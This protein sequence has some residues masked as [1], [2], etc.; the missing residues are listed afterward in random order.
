MNVKEKLEKKLSCERSMIRHKVLT[1]FMVI[2]LFPSTCY[3]A[4]N[5]EIWKRWTK[6]APQSEQKIDHQSWNTFLQRNVL[7]GHDGINRIDYANVPR[8]DRRNLKYYIEYL[9]A[10]TIGQYRKAEQLAYWINLYNALT[11]RLVIKNYPV[12]SIKDIDIS[13][14]FFSNGPWGKKFFEVEGIPI[15]LNDIEH[16]IL[17]PI[18]RDPRIHYV[19]NCASLG[20]PNLQPIALTARNGQAILEAAAKEFINHPRAVLVTRKGLILS[21]LYKWY[22][23][24]FGGKDEQ[25]I[26]HILRFANLQ[27]RNRLKQHNKISDY[28]YDWALNLGRL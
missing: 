27:L 8:A 7:V 28:Q 6:H 9:A 25:I 19:L 22:A 13:P 17:R 26:F 14:Q 16:R 5:K 20:C 10:V 23:E 24:D 12:G 4:P 18:W 15:S 2:F 1:F 3:A 21:S 11:V